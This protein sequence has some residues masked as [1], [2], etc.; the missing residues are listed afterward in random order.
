MGHFNARV[1]KAVGDDEGSRNREGKEQVAW[2]EARDLRFVIGTPMASAGWTSMV[3]EHRSV[4]DYI[5]IGGVLGEDDMIEMRVE[6]REGIDFPSDH[7][8]IWVH[9]TR[10]GIKCDEGGTKGHRVACKSARRRGLGRGTLEGISNLGPWL[11]GGGEQKLKW[12]K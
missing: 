2:V 12:R 5:M 6:D 7:K 3:G 11:V 8:L 9:I 4:I 1:W 10:S